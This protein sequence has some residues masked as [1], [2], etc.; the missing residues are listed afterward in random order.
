MLVVVFNHVMEIN[1][2]PQYSTKQDFGQQKKKN[3]IIVFTLKKSCVSFQYYF[4][5]ETGFVLYCHC[6][7]KPSQVKLNSVFIFLIF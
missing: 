7:Y 6:Y 1:S 2:T 5:F 3:P 4:L